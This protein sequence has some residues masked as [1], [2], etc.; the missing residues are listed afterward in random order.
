[1]LMQLMYGSVFFAGGLGLYR[2]VQALRRL[3]RVR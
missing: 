1:M 3:G 2:L